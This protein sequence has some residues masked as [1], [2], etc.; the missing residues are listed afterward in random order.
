MRPYTIWAPDYRRISGGI[1]ALYLLAHLLR[2]RGHQAEMKMTHG[3]WRNNPWNIPETHTNPADAIHIYPEIIN[4]NP[5]QS[6]RHVWWLLNHADKPG[7]RFVWHPAISNDPILNVPIID[8]NHFHPGNQ[9]RNRIVVWQG[10]TGAGHI[11]DGA[12]LITYQWPNSAQQLGDLLRTADHLI[13]YD[14]YSAVVHEATLCGCPVL[15]QDPKWQISELTSGPI[16]LHGVVDHPDRLDEARQ[17]V[18]LAWQEYVDY[19][20]KM[21]E[22]L[23]RFI[24]ITQ[25][26]P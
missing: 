15:I 16:P 14:G 3:P 25:A 17:T 21:E 22:Q 2:N 24:E 7:I 6:D 1:R 12:Q 11:P 18:N 13:A 8:L 9:Q 26:M 5:S 23:T 20:P 19:F 10:K 4:G